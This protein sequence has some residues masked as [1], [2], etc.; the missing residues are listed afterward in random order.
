MARTKTTL[1]P[2]KRK[3]M[4]ARGRSKRTLILDAIRDNALIGFKENPDKSDS[5]NRE[6]AEQAFF[7]HLVTKATDSADNDSGLCMRLLTERGWSALKPS[8][9][10]VM[11]EFDKDA[12]AHKQAAQVMDAI[13]SGVLQPDIGAMFVGGIKSMI[14]IETNTEIKERLEKLE[15]LINGG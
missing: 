8:S 10:L 5:E 1:T 13:A 2:E 3:D 7:R 14:D 12:P 9:E 15:A 6:A 11:F 4:P